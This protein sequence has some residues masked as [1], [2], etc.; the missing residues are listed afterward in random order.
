MI[1]WDNVFG[2]LL[3]L[4]LGHLV[5]QGAEVL[6]AHG[7]AIRNAYED[8][9]SPELRPVFW[10]EMLALACAVV[11]RLWRSAR[12]REVDRALWK[13]GIDA[14]RPYDVTN[15]AA[16]HLR[17]SGTGHRLRTERK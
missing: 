13:N 4:L 6:S 9:L 15:E 1:R 14:D 12:R 3:V 8:L 5:L 16:R 7:P 17:A 2:L 10:L 11:F